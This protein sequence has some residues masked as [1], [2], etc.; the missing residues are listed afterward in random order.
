MSLPL[1]L[2]LH[3][4]ALL[5][6]VSGVKTKVD[7]I[8]GL[9]RAHTT[10]DLQL[11]MR[12]VRSLRWMMPLGSSTL[13]ATGVAL[14]HTERLAWYTAWVVVPFGI[15]SF[16]FAYG[17]FV[18]AKE[19]RWIGQLVKEGPS[20]EL[21]PSLKKLARK[22]AMHAMLWIGPCSI[23]AQVYMMFS[24]PDLTGCLITEALAVVVGLMLSTLLLHR[25]NSTSVS[26]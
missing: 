4:G 6:L 9:G 24:K 22:P 2:T 20:G 25:W 1:L 5:V 7:V 8:R 23:V 15:V 17:W 14:A 10:E 3:V 12:D 13:L 18:E 19:L 11:A 16:F 26:W 21:T